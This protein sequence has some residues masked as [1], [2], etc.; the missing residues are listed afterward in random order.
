MERR[1][2]KLTA[3]EGSDINEYPIPSLG[4]GRDGGNH[5]HVP[6][7][8]VKG[9]GCAPSSGVSRGD[10]HVHT[11]IL[12]LLGKGRTGEYQ[13]SQL[14]MLR[15]PL[16]VLVVVVLILL[17]PLR[18]PLWCWRARHAPMNLVGSCARFGKIANVRL[19]IRS[20]WLLL[21]GDGAEL[22]QRPHVQSHIGNLPKLG[23][24]PHQAPPRLSMGPRA[25]LLPPP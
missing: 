15:W 17:R 14:P 7:S 3:P 10:Q 11:H 8:S 2:C 16:S 18:S 20:R 25:C 22:P 1:A 23:T 5:V 12:C 9:E 19:H 13:A 24:N 4:V 21:H 6:P